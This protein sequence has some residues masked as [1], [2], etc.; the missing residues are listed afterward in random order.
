M[1]IF[2]HENAKIPRLTAYKTI[3]HE[4]GGSGER[5]S[6][7]RAHSSSP[8][9][10][11]QNPQ[12]VNLVKFSGLGAAALRMICLIFLRQLFVIFIDSFNKFCFVNLLMINCYV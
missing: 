1:D 5:R 9:T 11:F 12:G 3:Y 8:L 7:P 6:H 10:K 2:S 4:G